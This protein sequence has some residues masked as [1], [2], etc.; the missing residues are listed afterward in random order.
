ML[1]K[2]N[3]QTP[4]SY[5]D[6][7]VELLF[8]YNYHYLEQLKVLPNIDIKMIYK[9]IITLIKMEKFN[10]TT[11][12][13]GNINKHANLIDSNNMIKYKKIIS[14]PIN[15][16]IIKHPNKDEKNK[17]FMVALPCTVY[18]DYMFIPRDNAIV[19]ILTSILQQPV[20]S[21][22]RTKHQ[23]GYMVGSYGY[24]D[25][26]NLYIMIKV[27]S[28][29]SIDILEKTIYNFMEEFKNILEKYDSDKF[30]K[31]KQ[32]VYDKLLEPFTTMN[33]INNYM[34]SEIKK[35]KFVFNRREMIAN[36]IKNIKLNDIIK[37]YYSIIQKRQKIIIC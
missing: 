21:E 2:K 28:E 30:N 31:M 11:L 25:N 36:E 9:R 29:K 15:D 6:M 8:P 3:T 35:E 7:M 10:I 1:E 34:L 14:K 23:L 16:I 12:W 22:L 4:W 24:Y 5:A 20:Y 19:M 37:L 18:K 32:S 13:Y 27:Q 33:D 26:I 17:C